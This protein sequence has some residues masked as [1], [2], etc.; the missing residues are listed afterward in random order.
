MKKILWH[1]AQASSVAFFL[2]APPTLFS[3]DAGHRVHNCEIEIEMLKN[4]LQS[5]EE[6]RSQLYKEMEESLSSVKKVLKEIE[7]H[8]DDPRQKIQKTIQGLQND[9][10][11]L[12]THTNQ[13]A[14]KINELSASVSSIK[15]D[16][17]G[18]TAGLKNLEEAMGLLSKALSGTL[19]KNAKEQTDTY[20]VQSGDSLEKI[21][22]KHSMTLA[23]LKELNGLSSSVI[24]VGQELYVYASPK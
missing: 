12:K 3:N 11:A 6:S 5:Q 13:L 19:P 2:L 8:K 14:S 9:L 16:I 18:H 7:S 4:S 15:K 1:F 20:K 17:A 22:K 21:A 24:R 23:Q 10:A